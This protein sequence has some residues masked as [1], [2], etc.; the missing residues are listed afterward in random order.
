MGRLGNN[1]FQ[2]AFASICLNELSKQTVSSMAF[3]TDCI[4]KT[5]QLNCITK[6]NNL[7]N[8]TSYEKKLIEN[9]SKNFYRIYDYEDKEGEILSISELSNLSFGDETCF[10]FDG[11]FQHKSYYEGKRNFLKSLFSLPNQNVQDKTAIHIRLTDY[12]EIKWT[13]PEEYY[14]RCISLANPTNLNVF[15]D[16]PYAPYIQKL[17][18]TG[19]TI[20]CGDP[21][22]DLSLMASHKKIIL[23]RSSYSWWGAVLSDAEEIYYPNPAS[24]FWSNQMPHKNVAISDENFILIDC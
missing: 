22:E 18:A 17:K 9:S 13:L 14:N 15:T 10:F 2:Y 7:K 21:I 5:T 19:A 24:G 12:N 4:P 16:D 23:S 6:F 3:N 11:F 1:M 20:I 8:E